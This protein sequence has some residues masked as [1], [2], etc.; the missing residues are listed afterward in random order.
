MSNAVYTVGRFQPPTIGHALLIERVKELGNGS[1]YVFVSSSRSPKDQ[2]PLTVEQKI[3][4]L[5]AMFPSGVTFVNTSTCGGCAGPVAANDYLRKMGYTD[6]TLVAG[7]D[8]AATFGSDA[9][10]WKKGKDNGIPPPNFVG[11]IRTEG[12]G[13]TSMSGTKA[14]ALARAGNYEAFVE[15]VKV[16]SIDDAATKA[17]YDAIRSPTGG[18]RRGGSMEDNIAMVA[19][20]DEPKTAGRRKTRRRKLRLSR[21]SDRALYRRGLQLRNGS[22]KTNRSSYVPRGYLTN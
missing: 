8:R 11:L 16:G 7:S 22:S 1:A 21:A 6:I 15:A 3:A 12:S 20:D 10:M 19:E 18:I 4:A 2:N 5:T 17:L 9:G 14:R 13:A